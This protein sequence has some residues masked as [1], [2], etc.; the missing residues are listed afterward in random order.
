MGL[1]DPDP[2]PDPASQGSAG[3]A[4]SIQVV[5]SDGQRVEVD[6]PVLVGRSPDEARAGGRDV[7]LLRVESPSQEISGTHLEL[8]PGGDPGTVDVVDL[9][10]TNGSVLDRPGQPH[11]ELSRADPTRLEVGD[12]VLLGDGVSL[13]LDG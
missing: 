4:G 5:V 8:R 7:R 1:A 13:R 3:S 6:R 2:D 12:A 9:G 10:S 11:Q